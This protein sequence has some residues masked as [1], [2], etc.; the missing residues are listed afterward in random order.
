MT[1]FIAHLALVCAGLLGMLGNYWFTFGLWP[2]SWWSFFGFGAL[3]ILLVAIRDA[4]EKEAR[5]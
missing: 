2:K 1:R 5:S 4:M 3:T